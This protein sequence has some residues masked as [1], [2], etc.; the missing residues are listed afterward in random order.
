VPS[1]L[2]TPTAYWRRLKQRL[3]L[4][5]LGPQ[6]DVPAGIRRALEHEDGIRPP[7]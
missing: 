1:I 7:R 3:R 5:W 4:W 2:Y 6:A